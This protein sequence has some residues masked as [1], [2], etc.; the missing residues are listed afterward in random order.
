LIHAYGVNAIWFD[1]WDDINVI[2]HPTWSVLWMQHNEHRIFF[3]NLIVL[4]LAH[5][6]HLNIHIEDYL[7]G[8][9]LMAAVGFF[10]A[11]HKRRSRSASWLYYCPVV[12]VM[13]SFVQ[14][15]N[16]LWGF[17]MAWYLVLVAL[18][19]VLFLLDRPML[20][21]WVMTG[22]IAAAVVGSFSLLQGLLIWPAGLV[23]LY[24]RSR[25]KNMVIVWTGAGVASGFLYFYHYNSTTAGSHYS[26]VFA[27]PVL[28]LEFFFSA[29]GDVV[30]EQLPVIGRNNGVLALGVIIVAVAIWVLINYGIR[31]NQ[32]GSA[33]GVALICFGLLFAVTI[34]LG[35][36]V[37]G[38]FYAD[39]SR[40]TTFDLL[41]VVGCYLAIRDRH[42]SRA[43]RMRPN[44]T[45]SQIEDSTEGDVLDLAT[46]QTTTERRSNDT[47]LVLIRAVVTFTVI[48]LFVYGIKNGL[49]QARA[50][51]G[52]LSEA[53]AV[54]V[55]IDKAP[56]D[57]VA[58][59]L[60]PQPA[61]TSLSAETTSIRRLAQVART[62]DLSVFAT[63]AARQYA[64]E[65]LPAESQLVTKVVV[66]AKDARVKGDVWLD[67]TASA[68][69]GPV[70][71]NVGRVDFD[72]TGGGLRNVVI[73][74]ARFTYLGWLDL[75]NTTTV[76]N[77]SY[78]LR[79][80]TYNST[81]APTDSKGIV[82]TVDNQ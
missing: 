80:V 65:G 62:R 13:S 77:G 82:V 50:W 36:A 7:S 10:I 29:I 25:P 32:Q 57:V 3:P 17:Q 74:S 22:A 4:A 27:H 54:T 12:I 78:T 24:I 61:P 63:S 23:L 69:I 43:R 73:G 1:Q 55:N 38:L 41:I 71:V 14:A 34:T 42:P 44:R 75:W 11:A 8:I 48:V 51:S 26:F 21:G 66:P 59:V 45:Q 37:Y 20:N 30:G 53:A 52:K 28:G 18:A 16:A 40:Y 15:G 46:P 35:R 6:T 31:R 67:A 60:Y 58:G 72:V 81:G 79:S 64:R 2:A 56:D 5:T 49:A 70:K 33:I 76:P 68:N 39:A 9:M 47:M 19:G